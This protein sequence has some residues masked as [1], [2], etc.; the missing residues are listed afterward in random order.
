MHLYVSRAHRHVISVRT[1]TADKRTASSC[2]FRSNPH[3]R[4]PGGL[5][6]ATASVSLY[7]STYII[8][9]NKLVRF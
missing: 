4:S 8:H 1:L 3:V 5:C 2:V 6:F 7:F 9:H